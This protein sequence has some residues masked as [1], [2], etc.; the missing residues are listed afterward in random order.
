MENENK[1]KSKTH[2]KRCGS[3]QTYVRIKD[4]SR[5]CRS[6]GNIEIIEE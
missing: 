5:V 4:G 3:G 1:L 6:C 2:C